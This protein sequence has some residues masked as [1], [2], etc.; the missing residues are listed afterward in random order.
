MASS[1]SKIVNK[2]SEGFSRIKYKFEY[3]DKEFETGAI[4]LK[5]CDC[6]LESRNLKDD[7]TKRK[8]WCCNKNYQNKFYEK[9]NKNYF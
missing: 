5:Y 2:L 3:N 1:L 6:F 4:K 7:S 8:C 9:L